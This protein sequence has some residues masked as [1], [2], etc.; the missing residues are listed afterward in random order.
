[1]TKSDWLAILRAHKD[2]AV[3]AHAE[4]KAKLLVAW[5]GHPLAWLFGTDLDSRPLIWTS[6]ELDSINPTKPY[7]DKEY[8]RYLIEILHTEPF[9]LIEKCRQ[10]IVSTTVLLYMDWEC[11]MV[12][13]RRWVLS[14]RT[15]QES[16]D[17]LRDKLRAVHL[18]LPMWVQA[19]LPIK[20]RPAG[21]L[22]Y[23]H[24]AGAGDSYILG[25]N[26][27]MAV[28]Q[29]RGG[30]ASGVAVDEGAYQDDLAGIIAAS[31]PMTQR[32]W[33]IT[34][35]A[36]GSPG[37][38]E[39]KR[40]IDEAKGQSSQHLMEGLSVKKAPSGFLIVTL[41]H[42]ADEAKR[43]P[44]FLESVRL[45]MGEKSF[46]REMLLDWTSPSGSAYYA[47]YQT[48]GGNDTYVRKCPGITGRHPIIYRGWDFGVRRPACVWGQYDP[49][50]RR[51]WIIR[52]MM[53]GFWDSSIN[54]DYGIDIRAFRDSVLFL[55]GQL[56]VDQ[57]KPAALDLV[58]RIAEASEY[59]LPPWF[60]P[61]GELQFSGRPVQ[62]TD[63]ALGREVNRRQESEEQL[64]TYADI[65]A[66]R[67]IFINDANENW[68]VRETV[69]RELLNVRPDGY[70]GILFD[71]AC[72]ILIAGYNGGIQYTKKTKMS[73]LPEASSRDGY[74]EHLH[75]CVNYVAV[76]VTPAVEYR[77]SAPVP[78]ALLRGNERI[79][80]PTDA[81]EFWIGAG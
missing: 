46:R 21:R 77:H 39:F 65:L 5:S 76:S 7:P 75:D 37:G 49:D 81:M 64:L 55:S 33:A 61:S 42:N 18:R 30:T 23:P 22:I 53:P 63:F 36:L 45:K 34:T 67:G 70:P 40:L 17:M 3:S 24:H 56:D 8:L 2:K 14:K 35:P 60:G 48:N 15:E 25:A 26:E 58:N 74:F 6:D 50:A 27:A 44:A 68:D 13:S 12:Q 47:E 10:M 57:M 73:A 29:A 11:R 66:E 78:T 32:C 71:P 52:E 62:F 72:P 59:P 54:T 79:E 16:K 4:D 43:D 41:R 69:M 80:T 20:P 1:M 19:V 51:L 28:G 38:Q 31:L 9:V